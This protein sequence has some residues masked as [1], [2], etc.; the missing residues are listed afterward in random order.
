MKKN[1]WKPL[2]IAWLVLAVSTAHI[3][4]LALNSDVGYCGGAFC[5]KDNDCMAPCACSPS[6]N[7]CYDVER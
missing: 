5:E 4:I 1:I 7:M 6:N 2:Q 3:S